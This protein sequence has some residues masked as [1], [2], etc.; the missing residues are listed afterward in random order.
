MKR[1]RVWCLVVLAVAAS[2]GPATAANKLGARSAMNGLETQIKKHDWAA[3]GQCQAAGSA[4]IARVKPFL[5]DGDEVVRL[6]AVDCVVAAGGDEAPRLLVGALSDKHPQVRSNAVNGLYRHVPKTLETE[7]LKVWD[8][9]KDE[10]LKYQLPMVLGLTDNKVMVS[11][12]VKR[13]GVA[14]TDESR[15]GLVVG[16]AKLGDARA[17]TEFEQRLLAAKGEEIKNRMVEVEYLDSAWVLP[18]LLPVLDHT[19]VAVDLSSH[20]TV[21]RR[22]GCDLAVDEVLRQRGDKFSFKPNP[23]GQ[24]TDAQVSQVRQYLAGLVES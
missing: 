2:I 24:Y 7:V 17:R 6:L 9:T 8:G 18:M 22:R 23:G 14:T 3:V 13:L 20:R 16:L 12:L 1:I 4:A 5:A 19:E 21:L 10:F 15:I 11:E